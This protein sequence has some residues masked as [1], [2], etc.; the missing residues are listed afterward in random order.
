MQLSLPK[1]QEQL[2]AII[3]LLYEKCSSQSDLT[4][5]MGII[6]SEPWNTVGSVPL[7]MSHQSH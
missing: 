2:E 1:V 7:F 4:R 6:A 3:L 5:S